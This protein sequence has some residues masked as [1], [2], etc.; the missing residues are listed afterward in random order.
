MGVMMA[1][2]KF[3][4]TSLDFVHHSDTEFDAIIDATK[5]RM[6]MFRRADVIPSCTA[7]ACR[8]GRDEC[9]CPE[10]CELP[11]NMVSDPLS[12]AEALLLIVAASLGL[13]ALV[14][15]GVAAMR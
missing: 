2:P 6:P 13:W 12:P 11:D 10:A 15:A 8:Q 1:E 9:P 4:K 3:A 7:D 14:A 5:K